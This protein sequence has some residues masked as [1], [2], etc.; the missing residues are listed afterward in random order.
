[1]AARGQYAKGVAKRAEIL[2]AALEIIDRNGY[3]GATVKELAEAVGLSQNGLLHYFGSKD[4]LFT[5]VIRHRG[6]IDMAKAQ[7]DSGYQQ[8]QTLADAMV[9]MASGLGDTPGFIQ[10][11]L[12]LAGEATEPAHVSHDYFRER[13]GIQRSLV[14][15]AVRDEQRAGRIRPDADPEGIAAMLF[16]MVDGLNL[17]SMYEPSLDAPA[18]VRHFFD[19]LGPNGHGAES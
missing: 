9:G 8:P 7:P 10:L 11:L 19:L 6:A 3:S 14:S 18:H 17:Q 13:Y 12:R 5:E 2:D 15:N 4:A 16:A 1:M